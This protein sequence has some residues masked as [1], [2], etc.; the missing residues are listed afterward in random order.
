MSPDLPSSRVMFAL[1]VTAVTTQP[2]SSPL[3]SLTSTVPELPL[4]YLGC[5]LHSSYTFDMACRSS[6][7]ASIVMSN[8]I[9]FLFPI[10]HIARHISAYTLYMSK[11]F[12][13]GLTAHK[14]FFPGKVAGC[15]SL[16]ITIMLFF[17]ITM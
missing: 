12:V 2:L 17:A 10:I 9:L 15:S 6:L 3:S 1:S 4:C 16:Y 13:I 5:S 14:H 7:P 8:F 11:L